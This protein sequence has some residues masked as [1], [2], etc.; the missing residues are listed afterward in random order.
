[1]SDQNIRTGVIKGTAWKFTERILAQTLS[2]IV[3]VIIARLLDPSDYGIVGLTTVFFSFANVF[4]SGGL[5]TALMQKKDADQDDY[6]TVFSVSFIVSLIIYLILF[7]LAPYIAKLY[8]QQVLIKLIR[9]LGI[10]LPIYAI[11]SVICAYISSNLQFKKFFFATFW[12]LVVSAVVGI[13]MA[14]KGYGVW[15]LAAQQLTN[16]IVGTIVLF[17]VTKLRLSLR[18][19]RERIKN[20]I[21]YG[22]K[23]MASSLMG[24]TITQINPLVIGRK[25]TSA[26]LSFYTKGKSFP[27]M[28]STSILNTIAAVLFPVLSKYQN[29]KTM[30]LRYTRLYMCIASFV[31][32]PAMLGFAG[33]AENFVRVVLG[34]KWL[35]SVYYIQIAC[36]AIIFDVISIGNCET[37]KAMGRSDVYLK[38]E[39]VKKCGYFI[40]LVLF[41]LFTN[42][43]QGLALS[44]WVCAVIQVTVNTIPNKK[45]IDYK[46]IQQLQDLVPNLILSMI[47]FVIVLA[48]GRLKI[49]ALL[50][51]CLQIA[52]GGILYILL[53]FITRNRTLAFLIETIKNLQ[54]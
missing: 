35:P 2:L 32:F 24:V 15:A 4:V 49:S 31:V 47:M 37:I 28:L 40:T 20:L 26:D 3:S 23:I 14:L 39:I 1:M 21:N 33:V 51:L 27:D 54:R 29:N 18:I 10:S 30:L 46:G 6:D 52:T 16:T 42:S 12:G 45:L 50:L 48:I 7:F 17:S 34:E 25:Y 22:W 53:A 11:K 44:S 5:N 13:S 19:A 43:P 8:D 36:F 38:M 41:L 9:V